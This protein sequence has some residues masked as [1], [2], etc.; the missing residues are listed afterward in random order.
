MKEKSINTLQCIFRE[1]VRA[2]STTSLTEDKKIKSCQVRLI[3]D[4]LKRQEIIGLSKEKKIFSDKIEF[5]E[6]SN[7]KSDILLQSGKLL[8]KMDIK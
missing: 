2:T 7:L 4:S 6:L 3:S 8:I 1:T 5:T